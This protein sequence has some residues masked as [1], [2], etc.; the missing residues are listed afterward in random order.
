MRDNLQV[1]SVAIP[2]AAEVMSLMTE[3]PTPTDELIILLLLSN[4]TYLRQ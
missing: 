2:T 4:C 1:I 3:P